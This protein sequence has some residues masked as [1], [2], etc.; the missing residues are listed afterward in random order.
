[1]KNNYRNIFRT[2]FSD[3]VTWLLVVSFLFVVSVVTTIALKHRV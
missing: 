2:Y 3:Y 1:M